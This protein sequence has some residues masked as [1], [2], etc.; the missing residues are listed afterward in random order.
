[1]IIALGGW[2]SIVPSS[3]ACNKIEQMSSRRSRDKGARTERAIVRLLQA[4]GIAATKTSGMCTPGADISMPLLGSDRAVE[5][6][7]RATGFRQL[8]DW[9]NNGDILIVKSNRQKP[10]VVLRLSLAA[11]IAN[12]GRTATT[13]CKECD[14]KGPAS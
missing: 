11:E 3:S 2:L 14:I 1:M 7:C 5:V 9:L 6:K 8:Y 12:A 13:T 4:Q 10:L